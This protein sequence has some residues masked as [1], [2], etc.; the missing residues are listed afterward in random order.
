MPSLS[1]SQFPSNIHSVAPTNIPSAGP[2]CL[3]GEF[4]GR[5]FYIPFIQGQNDGCV[6]VQ[7]F[8]T[9]AFSF[10]N[11][12]IGCNN[13][14]F[15]NILKFGVFDSSLGNEAV[16]ISDGVEYGW[17]GNF[18]I[19]E[20][21]LVQD[22]ALQTTVFDDNNKV[23]GFNFVVPRCISAP[24]VMPSTSPSMIPSVVHSLVPTS[25]P[26]IDTSVTPTIGS[27]CDVGAFTGQTYYIVGSGNDCYKV[28][29]ILEEFIWLDTQNQN[30]Q[31][32]DSNFTQQAS[33]SQYN[34]LDGN[35]ATF[36]SGTSQLQ[37][38]GVFVM[39]ESD[40]VQGGYSTQFISIDSDTKSFV[41]NLLFSQCL[42]GEEVN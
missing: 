6:K 34:G 35:Q 23:F 21:S 22:I 20:D 13:D 7:F 8:E 17:R 33:V 29:L 4:L 26:S 15:L 16:F 38:S 10:D 1:P 14:S 27:T 41:I 32:T 9:G 5:T 37:W 18:L 42:V 24:S 30:C 3:I 31:N 25:I 40:N 39:K 12:N 28:P 36:A 11:T 19:K 2:T